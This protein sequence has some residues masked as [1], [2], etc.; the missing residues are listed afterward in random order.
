MGPTVKTNRPGLVAA[1]VR[2]TGYLLKD[3]PERGLYD[4][5]LAAAVLSSGFY[6]HCAGSR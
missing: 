6:N 4:V 2:G 3:A 5:V 1:L